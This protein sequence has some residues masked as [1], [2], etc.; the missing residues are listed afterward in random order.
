MKIGSDV[1]VANDVTI[2]GGVSIGDGAVIA[3]NSH[4]VGNIGAYEVWG[5]NPAK[6]N[7]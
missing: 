7:T 3:M 4:V 5:G 2:I 1:W 6:K